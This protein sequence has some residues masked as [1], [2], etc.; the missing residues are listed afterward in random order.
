M[1]NSKKDV[2]NYTFHLEKNPINLKLLNNY[3]NY[4][5]ST[6]SFL[7]TVSTKSNPF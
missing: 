4:N 1:M 2:E 5:T 7:E 3:T 6:E